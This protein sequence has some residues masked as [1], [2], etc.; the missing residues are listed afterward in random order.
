ME[1]R[2]PFRLTLTAQDD[3]TEVRTMSFTTTQSLPGSGNIPQQG[4]HVVILLDRHN[5]NVTLVFCING[6]AVTWTIGFSI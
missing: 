1:P 3:P 6:D 5:V 2:T 4:A